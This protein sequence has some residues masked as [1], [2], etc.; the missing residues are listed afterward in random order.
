MDPR[1]DVRENGSH[2]PSRE[3]LLERLEELSNARVARWRKLAR[4]LWIFAFAV[5]VMAF[6]VV[7]ISAFKAGEALA[8]GGL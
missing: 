4:N 7:P 8:V 6:L 5:I 1:D 2:S 3:E